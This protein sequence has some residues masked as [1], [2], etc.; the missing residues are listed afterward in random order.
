M[1]KNLVFAGIGI[2]SSCI[3]V[4]AFGADPKILNSTLA[5]S[6]YD[7][8]PI[9]LKTQLH[10]WMDSAR[11]SEKLHKSETPL[12]LIQPHAGYLYSG[13]TAGYGAKL[14]RGRKFN[15]VIL[16][17]PS[18]RVYLKNNI[19]LHEADIFRTP[20]G[21]LQVDKEVIQALQK[22]PF[23]QTSDRVHQG[24]HCIQI[25]LPFLQASLA[26]GFKIVPVITGQTDPDHIRKIAKMFTAFLTPE[27]LVVISSDFTHFGK[28]FGYVPFKNDF[29]ENLR[30]LDLH[31][32]SF[33]Q[34]KNCTGFTKYV[35]DTGATICGE[36]PIRILLEMLPKNA[37]VSLLKYSTSAEDNADYSHSVSYISAFAGGK[38]NPEEK[39]NANDF[40][41]ATE[42][43]TL[44]KMARESIMYAFQNRK[45]PVS[46]HFSAQA[47]EHMK[48]K[49][50]CFV[51][52]KIGDDLR[53]CIGEITPLRSL[54]QA[55]TARAC[56]SAF[57]DPRFPQLTLGEFRTVE[58]EI[59]ALTPA[60]PIN[61]WKE[62]EI[63]KHGMT[64]TKD[65]HSAVFLPQVATE[66][67][68]TLEET[69]SHL[70]RKA[71]LMPDAY[72]AKD[73]VFTVFE[74]VVFCESDFSDNGQ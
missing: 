58:I 69:L 2:A 9:K 55:V 63:G 16:I 4:N 23:V 68:W 41:T 24:E 67:G 11:L 44:L 40:L 20:L 30:K 45:S 29:A 56:D 18:H 62:I 50:G 32:F 33:I 46:T 28:G 52:L 51:T 43:K 15:R 74:A 49:A 3:T 8:D 59:S 54:Y 48:Q 10:Q 39:L 21:D 64:I 42:K 65:G 35:A 34:E 27:T 71:G 73:A 57:R 17:G 70:S 19:C 13:A 47:T 26:E 25:Q 31:A 60:K 5:G 37:E 1:N 72:K 7:A 61:S 36:A 22:Y 38:W 53:G 66:Q 6:W 14:I 12:A